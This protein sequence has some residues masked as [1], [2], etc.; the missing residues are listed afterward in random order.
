MHIRVP[1]ATAAA[2]CC[3]WSGAAEAKGAALDAGLFNMYEYTDDQSEISLTICGSI[4]GSEG[5]YGG[6]FFGPF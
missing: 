6:K 3:V 2:L 4:P 5:C 1:L